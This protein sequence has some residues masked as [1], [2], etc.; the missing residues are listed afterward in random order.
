VPTGSADEDLWWSIGRAILG[1]LMYAMFRV[2][3]GGL[4]N[5]PASGGAILASNHVSVFDPVILGLVASRR[6]RTVRFVGAYE[7]WDVPV[8]GWG[9]RKIR[10][11]PLVRGGSDL[12]ALEVAARVVRSGALAGIYPE[13]RVG[14]GPL[15]PGKRGTARLSLASKGPVIPVGIWGTNARWPKSGL[16]WSRPLRPVVALCVGAPITPEGDPASPQDVQALTDRLMAGI[17]HQVLAARSV[18]RIP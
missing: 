7:N 11:I 1:P 17:A 9:L 14:P 16:H 15:L 13:G 18:A 6:G 10:Q 4:A 2:R 3:A 12:R 8:V 5:L